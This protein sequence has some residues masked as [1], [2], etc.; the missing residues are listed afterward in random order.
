[1]TG[2][3]TDGCVLATIVSGFSKGYNFVMLSDLIEATDLPIRQEL[4][5]CLKDYTFPVMY[6]KTM[7]SR[8][9]LDSWEQQ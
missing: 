9:F 1:M 8:E 4:S 3:F 7:T 6:G 2:V 5:K